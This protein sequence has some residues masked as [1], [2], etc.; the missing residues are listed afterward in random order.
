ML[1]HQAYF[2]LTAR[3][4]YT[5]MFSA[6]RRCC[7]SR[8]QDPLARGDHRLGRIWVV[9][10]VIVGQEVVERVRQRGLWADLPNQERAD[11]VAAH[12]AVYKAPDLVGIPHELPLDRGN[13]Y[14]LWWMPW[15]ISPTVMGV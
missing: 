2:F 10:R 6:V 14:S 8:M 13:R 7:P 11:R 12:Q 5:A 3:L 9:P 1:L 15:R 4:P